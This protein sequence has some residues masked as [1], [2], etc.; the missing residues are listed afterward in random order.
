MTSCRI[1]AAVLW[2]HNGKCKALDRQKKKIKQKKKKKENFTVCTICTSQ[3]ILTGPS[4]RV[5]DRRCVCVFELY[6]RLTCELN[7]KQRNTPTRLMGSGEKTNSERC[8]GA[9]TSRWKR[10]DEASY[11]RHCLSSHLHPAQQPAA[12]LNNSLNHGR[13]QPRKAAIF[14]H[15]YVIMSRPFT[16]GTHRGFTPSLQAE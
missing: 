4:Y 3:T 10:L 16:G 1:R 11:G 8:A 2:D 7:P 5:T 15:L 13:L 9:L 14:S 12:F 6:P